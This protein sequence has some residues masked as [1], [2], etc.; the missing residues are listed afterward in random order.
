MFNFDY[1]KEIPE[2]STLHRYCVTQLKG[3]NMPTLM[4]LR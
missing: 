2:L 1:L 3:I 4:C